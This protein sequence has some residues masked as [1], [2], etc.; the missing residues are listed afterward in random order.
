M[1]SF[2]LPAITRGP[3]VGT[4]ASNLACAQGVIGGRKLVST[5][6]LP[7]RL[8]IQT[9]DKSREACAKATDEKAS[10]VRVVRIEWKNRFR[11]F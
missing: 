11:I 3:T 1:G 4:A 7:S 9:P 5:T 2:S 10:R 8:L 6:V